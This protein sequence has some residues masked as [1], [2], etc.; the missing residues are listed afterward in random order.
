MIPGFMRKF[1]KLP[2]TPHLPL[3]NIEPDQLIKIGELAKQYG[4]HLKEH[5]EW[6]RL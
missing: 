3:G 2:V 6:R 1:V 4:G 5:V